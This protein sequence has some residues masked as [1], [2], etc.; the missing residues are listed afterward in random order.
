MD[1]KVKSFTRCLGKDACACVIFHNPKD[2]SVSPAKDMSSKVD[3]PTTTPT[4]RLA[5]VTN[6]PIFMTFSQDL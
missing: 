5:L 2:T 1:V 4:G 6:K 3:A